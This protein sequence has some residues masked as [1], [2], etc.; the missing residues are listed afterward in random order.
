MMNPR[1]DFGF[2]MELIVPDMQDS[3][4]QNRIVFYPK[5]PEESQKL[6]AKTIPMNLLRKSIL[7]VTILRIPGTI[8]TDSEPF[9]EIE[10]FYLP[11]LKFLNHD[12]VC[13]I[14]ETKGTREFQK[15]KI[16][17]E[18]TFKSSDETNLALKMDIV[19]C[20][21]KVYLEQIDCLVFSEKGFDIVPPRELET[22]SS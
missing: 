12:R 19:C 3:S 1:S 8:E 9:E 18:A 22:A 2:L 4:D 5:N 6:L 20:T 21:S 16:K 13:M 14:S 17:Y 15:R 7:K 11:Y 10:Q